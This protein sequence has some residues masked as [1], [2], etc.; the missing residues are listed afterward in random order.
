MNKE[1]GMVNGVAIELTRPEEVIYKQ[2]ILMVHGGSQ[3]SWCWENYQSYFSSKGFTA[4]SLNW[5]H[6]YD[7]RKLEESEFLKRSILDVATEIDV[8]VNSLDQKPILFGHSMGALASLH[9][10]TFK[11]IAAL[12][13]LAPAIP[14]KIGGPPIPVPIDLDRPRDPGPFEEAYRWFFLGS[15]LEDAQKY[16]ALLDPESPQ[17]VYEAINSTTEVDF[18]NVHCPSLLIGAGKDIV[19]PHQKVQILAEAIHGTYL[20]LYDSSHNLLLEPQWQK[21]TDLIYAWLRNNV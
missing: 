13:L 19:V 14:S 9:Y 21:T 12:V 10:S 8:V 11:P 1:K 5:F 3:G 18:S 20:Y 2:P 16:Y 17:A 4:I 7:S 15:S 6:H